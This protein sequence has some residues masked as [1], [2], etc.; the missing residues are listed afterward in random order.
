MLIELAINLEEELLVMKQERDILEG[1]E[2]KKKKSY[3]SMTDDKE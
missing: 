2:N 1:G 3:V